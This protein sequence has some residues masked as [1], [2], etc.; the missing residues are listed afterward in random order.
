MVILA[1]LFAGYVGS[2]LGVI[3]IALYNCWREDRP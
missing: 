3:S 1:C 2:I